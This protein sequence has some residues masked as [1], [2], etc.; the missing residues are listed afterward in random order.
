M[1][2]SD[3]NQFPNDDIEQ[4]L[5]RYLMN[6]ESTSDISSSDKQLKT[7]I[8]EEDSGYLIEVEVTGFDKDEIKLYIEDN[9]L[10]IEGKREDI[11]DEENDIYIKQES[12][13]AY[14]QRGF[15]L[16]GINKNEIKAIYEHGFIHIHLPKMVINNKNTEKD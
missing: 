11:I 5:N 15:S 3:K 1:N 4:F 14:C 2:N 7:K 8:Y 16:E 6:T 13:Y 9:Q 12:N 10:F